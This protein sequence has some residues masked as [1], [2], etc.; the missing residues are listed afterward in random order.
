MVFAVWESIL[1][2][3]WSAP[4]TSVLQRLNDRRVRQFWDPNHMVAAILKKAEEDG[5]LHPDCCV[6]KG[7]LWDLAAVYAPGKLWPETLSQPVLFDGP[8]VHTSRELDSVIGKNL[9]SRL[10]ISS[11]PFSVAMRSGE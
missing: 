11:R 7:F 9:R 6:R 3:D 5:Q 4:G 8:V 2:T 1:P 10:T